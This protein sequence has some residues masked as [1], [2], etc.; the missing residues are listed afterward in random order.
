MKKF[1]TILFSIMLCALISMFAIGPVQ[2]YIEGFIWLP[3]YMKKGYDSHY[4]EYVVIYKHGSS[5]NLIVPVKNDWYPNG[6]NVSKVIIG[7]DWGQN[8][9]LNISANIEQVGWQETEVFTVSFTADATEAVSSDW[10]HEYTIYVEHVNATTGPTEIVSPTW[11][12]DWNDFSGPDY[13]F[14]VFSTD[15]ADALDLSEEYDSYASAYPTWSFNNINA[16]Q[17]A[18][19]ASIEASLGDTHY[20]RGDY[21]S[22]ETRYQNA[23][24]LYSQALAAEAEW[25]TKVEEANLEIA[26]TEADANLSTAIAMLRQADAAMTQAY[27]WILFGLG[28]V[29]MGIATIV[30]AYRKPVAG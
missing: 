27:A 24:D 5:V 23:L 26:L 15:Q 18:G 6:L 14:V 22:A 21:A 28:F 9:T 29:F 11:E 1:S 8:K 16:S 25:E 3:P 7:F 4:E 12:V 2:A 13:K 19:Q 30:Y 20:T 10:A 17:L